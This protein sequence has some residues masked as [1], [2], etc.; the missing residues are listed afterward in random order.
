MANSKTGKKTKKTN[1]T[2]K[3]VLK[4]T[5]FTSYGNKNGSPVAE[6]LFVKLRYGELVARTTTNNVLN[7]YFFNL[8]GGF[9]PN[10]TGTG[11]QPMGWDQLTPLYAS[12]RI[13]K[14]KYRVD[15]QAP[16]Y[17][18][19]DAYVAVVPSNNAITISAYEA[20]IELPRQKHAVIGTG[21]PVVL[22]GN[23][24]LST[25][26]GQTKAEFNGND[27]TKA[28]VSANPTE[29]QLLGIYLFQNTGGS[30]VIN[31]SVQLEYEVEFFD[32]VEIGQ[33]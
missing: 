33:S 28:L 13:H 4:N 9:D 30:V 1:K 3:M 18:T 8:N 20:S 29:L 27:G 17:G 23:V 32:P 7:S 14:C 19:S 2:K 10:Y 6:R 26:M 22:S 16:P 25:L 31:Y 15:F 5:H 21:K 11:H 24:Q 12:Y